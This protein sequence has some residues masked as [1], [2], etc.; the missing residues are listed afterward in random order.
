MIA[1]LHT[2]A[3]IMHLEIRQNKIF[4]GTENRRF[5]VQISGHVYV[6]ANILHFSRGES[7]DMSNLNL[8]LNINQNM[9]HQVSGKRKEKKKQV[10]SHVVVS[11]LLSVP[12]LPSASHSMTSPLF[13]ISDFWLVETGWLCRHSP[14]AHSSADLG[15]VL[16]ISFAA[17]P[18]SPL[19]NSVRGKKNRKNSRLSHLSYF[20]LVQALA[21]PFVVIVIPCWFLGCRR[22]SRLLTW[23]FWGGS[24]RSL[25]IHFIGWV[26]LLEQKHGSTNLQNRWKRGSRRGTASRRCSRCSKNE[27]TGSFVGFFVVEKNDSDLNCVRGILPQ[28][29]N[30]LR[31]W[32]AQCSL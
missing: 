16:R 5:S 6:Q 12:P 23:F 20:F 22:G 18:I 9:E 26:P 29:S 30:V 2:I 24:L 32:C 11:L 28:F 14:I 21:R 13:G 1:V 10:V 15:V 8:V 17:G 4:T 19:R 27:R 25:F 31:Q 3:V 7:S